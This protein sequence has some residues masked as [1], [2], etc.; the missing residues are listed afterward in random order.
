MI[1]TI[2][3]PRPKSVGARLTFDIADELEPDLIKSI[4]V[5]KDKIEVDA[6]RVLSPE[7]AFRIQLI[8]EAHDP[9]ALTDGAQELKD[10][11]KLV[12]QLSAVHDAIDQMD[13]IAEVRAVLKKL[14]GVVIRRL[15]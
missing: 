3:Y 15:K 12:N 1:H 8:I 9:K 14:V 4:T 6:A 13:S 5:H 7:E 10:S 11:K 2:I